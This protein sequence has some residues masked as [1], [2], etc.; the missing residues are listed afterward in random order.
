MPG[1]LW[2]ANHWSQ[3]FNL[4]DVCSPKSRREQNVRDGNPTVFA[5]I[6]VRPA[7]ESQ[8]FNSRSE[9]KRNGG[10]G[11]STGSPRSRRRMA[12]AI[13]FTGCSG[14]QSQ[15]SKTWLRRKEL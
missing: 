14:G 1:T 8:P 5:L 4:I 13:R 3:P 7:D 11:G 6:I 10:P 12:L 2:L 15:G 9:P